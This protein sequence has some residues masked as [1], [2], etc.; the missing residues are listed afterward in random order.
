MK[1]IIL[2]FLYFGSA[3]ILLSGNN[4]NDSLK[5]YKKGAVI[6][7]A[8]RE[9][10]LQKNSPSI[11][12][13]ISSDE[14]SNMN[15]SQLSEK[16]MQVNGIFLKDYGPGGLKTISLHGFGPEHCLV[17]FNGEKLNSAQNGN[18]DLS[19][20]L[21]E[22]I[23]RIEILKGGNS[24]YFGS[25]A[26]SGV[27]NLI[28]KTPEKFSVMTTLSLG[29]Y[30]Y[31]KYFLKLENKI[32]NF[33][34]SLSFNQ[35][36]AQNDFDYKFND[37]SDIYSGERKNSDYIS[38]QYQAGFNYKLNETSSLN[39]FNSGVFSDKGV[40]DLIISPNLSA[41]QKDK[42]ILSM[43]V[44]KNKL[45]EYVDL[46]ISP[47]FHYSEMNYINPKLDS[48]EK[49]Y[50]SISKN[51]IT[52]LNNQARYLTEYMDFSGGLEIIKS[53]TNSNNYSG[54]KD[55]LQIGM[56]LST[57]Y[58]FQNQ[59]IPV[60]I[61]PAIR[62]DNYSD[63]GNAISPKIGVNIK[64]KDDLLI[65]KSTYSKNFRAPTF[66]ELF[67]NPGGNPDIKP[68]KSNCFDI[69]LN[70]RLEFPI[71]ASFELSYYNIK[72]DDR[73]LWLPS[74]GYIWKPKNI[75]NV[76]SS[77][78]DVSAGFMLFENL[79]NLNIDYAYNV[80]KNTTKDNENYDKYLPYIPVHTLKSTAFITFNNLRL[81]LFYCLTGE[82]YSTESNERIS[83]LP[84]YDYLNGSIAYDIKLFGTIV[85]LKFE[86]NNVFDSEYTI[87]PYYPTALRNYKFNISIKY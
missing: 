44:Y 42:D 54:E 38:R 48:E 80:S 60:I 87:M 34:Y 68:E 2:L 22:D 25:E 8:T 10:I 83:K 77:G 9:E 24:A 15:G 19:N 84:Y 7:S 52:G 62:Y 45:N 17:L 55:R 70:Y 5:T 18:V 14:I 12:K 40:P 49:K 75:Q 20:Y 47:K 28:P 6:V 1:R 61:Y 3:G 4:D 29:S 30:D 66:N 58:E 73:I 56:F 16:L 50:E 23:E 64:L 78:V 43:L 82:R 26:L 31:Y 39:L 85:N 53:I 81:N 46:K 76:N 74:G 27:I 71:N 67:W 37:K 13:V 72:M 32:E 35:E 11:M 51:Y 65:L 69:G 21:T 86:T 33:D 63:F 57:A 79:L 59:L 41:R 36:K